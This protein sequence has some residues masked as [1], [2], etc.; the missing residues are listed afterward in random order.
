MKKILSFVLSLA[1]ILSLC[2]CGE[3]EP[4]DATQ[5]ATEAVEEKVDFT[6]LGLGNDPINFVNSAYSPA[7]DENYIYYNDA[8]NNGIYRVNCKGNGKT[9]VTEGK[10]MYLNIQGEFLY[11]VYNAGYVMEVYQ[12]NTETLEEERIFMDD[13]YN[14]SAIEP[15]TMLATDNLIIYAYSDGDAHAAMAYNM[16][17]K[18]HITL[19]GDWDAVSF[20]TITADENKDIYIRRLFP[21]G[22]DDLH[23]V[24]LEDIKNYEPPQ[25]GDM[26]DV[27]IAELV[28][29]D[30]E[31][32]EENSHMGFDSIWSLD[33][34]LVALKSNANSAPGEVF[35]EKNMGI[36]NSEKVCDTAYQKY[37]NRLYEWNT[38]GAYKGKLYI[39]ESAGLYDTDKGEKLTVV[40]GKGEYKRYD[41]K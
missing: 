23:C 4:E 40:D 12:I 31:I 24:N 5:A 6:A 39:I 27:A 25:K 17:T 9:L 35:I 22:R 33:G 37:E 14:N 36:P 18:E 1:L 41:V 8:P 15:F 2:A 3:N 30:P 10:N 20:I 34:S 16:E 29:E 32:S 26:G 13:G 19:L 28:E 21:D 7:F 11:Y 38:Y